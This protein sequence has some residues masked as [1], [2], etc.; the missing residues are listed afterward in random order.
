MG[1]LDKSPST[2]APTKTLKP[3]PPGDKTKRPLSAGSS[4]KSSKSKNVR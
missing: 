1:Q 4:R 2:I 3:P